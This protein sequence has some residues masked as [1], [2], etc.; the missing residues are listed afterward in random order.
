MRWLLGKGSSITSQF[1]LLA[2]GQIFC[3]LTS[4]FCPCWEGGESYLLSYQ[5]RVFVENH[6][7]CTN[8]HFQK[9][10]EYS[11]DHMQQF[12]SSATLFNNRNAIIK[13]V[14]TP[15]R[16]FLRFFLKDRDIWRW[17][18]V[19]DASYNA[20]GRLGASSASGASCLTYVEQRWVGRVQL[21]TYHKFCEIGPKSND[22][23]DTD[24]AKIY[25]QMIN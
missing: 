25:L 23:S 21:S 19:S 5:L 11:V 1:L 6:W 18:L 7:N 12:E 16:V 24:L 3:N 14:W 15:T 20:S 4:L 8:I 22:L 10:I 13:W 2:K 9:Q 17:I